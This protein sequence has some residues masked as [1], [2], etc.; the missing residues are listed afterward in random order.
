MLANDA[1][2]KCPGLIEFIQIIP[3][4]L[5][6]PY[7]DARYFDAPH[8]GC[9]FETSF[10]ETGNLVNMIFIGSPSEAV[11]RNGT[12]LSPEVHIAILKDVWLR[13]TAANISAEEIRSVA[14]EL[15]RD[16]DFY[17]SSLFLRGYQTQFK[18]ERKSASR[19]RCVSLYN[20]LIY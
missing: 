6:T 16:W 7:G 1:P 12:T 11:N 19:N 2:S 15:A 13:R 10:H 5:L 3:Q 4:N 8:L 18:P 14:I 20:D 9:S 17:P